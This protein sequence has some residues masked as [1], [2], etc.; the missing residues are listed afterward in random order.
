[1]GVPHRVATDVICIHIDKSLKHTISFIPGGPWELSGGLS[2][3]PGPIVVGGA[4]LS[5][6]AI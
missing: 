3:N 2:R 6:L 1:M 4:E 5:S